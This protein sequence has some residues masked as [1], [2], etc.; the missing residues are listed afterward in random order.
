MNV[1]EDKKRDMTNP[2]LKTYAFP[3]FSQIKMEHILPAIEQVISDNKK[4]I[5]ALLHHASSSYTWQS[6]QEPL[7]QLYDYFTKAWSP[8]SHLNH[9]KHSPELR[10]QHDQCLILL[11]EF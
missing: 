9:V 4:G 8:I 5:E 10:D 7:D 3:P 6:F 1:I 2:L 11:S